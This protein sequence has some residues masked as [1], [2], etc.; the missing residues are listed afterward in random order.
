MAGPTDAA[1]ELVPNEDERQVKGHAEGKGGRRHQQERGPVKKKSQGQQGII[2]QSQ[3]GIGRAQQG[4]I[5][6]AEEDLAAAC[7]QFADV[8]AGEEGGKG[9][10]TAVKGDGRGQPTYR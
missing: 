8:G 1:F 3:Q 6:G 9:S 2:K 7:F 5:L 4:G 10:V